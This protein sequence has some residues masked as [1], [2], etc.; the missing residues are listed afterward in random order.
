MFEKNHMAQSP[1]LSSPASTQEPYLNRQFWL[2][3]YP[4][5]FAIQS[6]SRRMI[7]LALE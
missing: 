6:S 3:H 1:A 5:R 4:V 2:Q 7:G